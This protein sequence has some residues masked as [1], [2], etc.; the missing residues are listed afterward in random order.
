MEYLINDEFERTGKEFVMSL[1]EDLLLHF[2]DGT[3][4]DH[5]KLS[6]DHLFR[7]RFETD[8]SPIQMRSANAQPTCLC[9]CR[10]RVLC[11]SV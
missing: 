11:V 9:S 2:P 5:E 6:Q 4:E 7:T 8:T 3:L 10:V 1:F